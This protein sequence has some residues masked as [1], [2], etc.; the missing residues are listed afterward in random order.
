[1]KSRAILMLA[2]ALTAGTVNA[3]QAGFSGVTID[4]KYTDAATERIVSS[5]KAVEL[6]D[7]SGKMQ[8][9]L[10]VV[11][12]SDQLT[13]TLAS[14]E[15]TCN[16]LVGS[17]DQPEISPRGRPNPGMPGPGIP[18][19]QEPQFTAKCK[20]EKVKVAEALQAAMVKFERALPSLRNQMPSELAKLSRL[21]E[22]VRKLTKLIR[23]AKP[24]P[25]FDG[26]LR[27]LEMAAGSMRVTTGGAQDAEKFRKEVE[28][29]NIPTPKDY[30]AYGLM[31][32]FDLYVEGEKCNALLCMSPVVSID[33]STKKMYV[34]VNLGTN[35]DVASFK[36]RPL[37]V[38]VCLDES[39]S[40]E[41]KDKSDRTRLDW[42]KDAIN[43]TLNNLVAGQDYFTLVWFSGGGGPQEQQAG[44]LWSPKGAD[45]KARAITE[46]DK[47]KIRA[48][49]SEQK[50]RSA[51]N[52]QAG[53]D[54]SY[55]ELNSVKALLK[56][57]GKDAGYE[58]RVIMISDANFNFDTDDGTA[59]LEVQN[60]SEL[61]NINLTTIGIGQNF[62]IDFVNKLSVV[63]GGNFIF[64]QDGKR[65]MEYFEQFPTLVTPV[66]YKFKATVGYDQAK[67]KL[68]RVHGVPEVKP[69]GA[70]TPVLGINTLF[71]AAPKEKGGGAQ[72]LEFDLL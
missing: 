26:R 9:T 34:Q 36:R 65:M 39:G 18:E 28:A 14:Y 50:T 12:I 53:L 47:M 31:N 8:K 62:F 63:Q 7:S 4:W 60:Q 35:V 32:E 56:A 55:K 59:I 51:T 66:A 24:R 69:E 38:G 1:M 25:R 58:H 5:S 37:N 64:A 57:E 72:V 17:P 54:L 49:V 42:A 52:L 43:E 3:S 22:T 15:K 41:G 23:E 2:T 16:D 29:G 20:A 27:S 44:T 48:I 21:N 68:V 40:M 33:Q 70:K 67:A 30:Q 6:V 61:N 19:R 71:F 45:G 11:K 46:D 10:L 13:Q